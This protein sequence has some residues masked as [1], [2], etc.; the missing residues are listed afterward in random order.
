MLVLL[1]FAGSLAAAKTM[2]CV[3]INYQQ[4]IVKPI[5]FD[6]NTDELRSYPFIISMNRCD[7]NCNTTEDQFGRTCVSKKLE[8]VNLKVFNI[9]NGI[10]ELKTLVKH[11]S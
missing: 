4:Y 9:I 3:S 7:G 6:L 10:N 11:I 1:C 8:D 2:K 5:L